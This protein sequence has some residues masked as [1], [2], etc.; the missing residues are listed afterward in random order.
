VSQFT[1][2]MLAQIDQTT[3]DEFDLG[4]RAAAKRKEGSRRNAYEKG[5][6]EVQNIAG[7]DAARELTEW[8]ENEI[9]TSGR[10]PTARSVRK[11]GAKICR[12]REHEISAGSWLGA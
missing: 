12:D 1:K 6:R 2:E 9:R 11:R 10:F 3:Q 8:I 5:I 7:K 4:T